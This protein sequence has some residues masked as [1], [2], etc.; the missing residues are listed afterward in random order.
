MNYQFGLAAKPICP[1]SKSYDLLLSG[2]IYL[3]FYK[4][5]A[6]LNVFLSFSKILAF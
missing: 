6:E 3:Q 4:F 2:N 5:V 1:E